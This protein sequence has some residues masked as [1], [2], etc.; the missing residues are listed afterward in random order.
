MNKNI[1]QGSFLAIAALASCGAA[2]A[3]DS[4]LVSTPWQL[5]F[6]VGGVLP[7]NLRG[8]S[9]GPLA[10]LSVGL[11]LRPGAYLEANVFG[12]R[13]SGD[14]GRDDEQTLGG[15]LDLRLERL[16]ED[17]LRY[18]F[19]FGGGYS[20]TERGSDTISAPYA[21]IGY[22]IGYELIPALEL[23]AEI[24]G[25]V[26]IDKGFIPG[27]GVTYDATSSVG[28]VYRLGREPTVVYESSRL[29][30]APPI[31]AAAPA[32]LVPNVASL[33]ARCPVAPD[34]ARVDAS[35]CLLPQRLLLPRSAFFKAQT[36]FAMQGS[37]DA[38]LYSLA[39]S[40]L[41]D[42]Q[43][44]AEISVHSEARGDPSRLMALTQSQADVLARE[45]LRQGITIERFSATGLG[46]SQPLT[47][48]ASEAA[49]EQNRR[50]E[51]NLIRR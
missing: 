24:R 15:G 33:D 39:M 3:A 21:N 16:G 49:I 11:P 6:S 37:G 43:L 32:R 38:A 8:V 40:L 25:L 30:E 17:R 14:A 31:A 51:I 46:G 50:V 47:R 23:R 48:E 4:T 13:A 18:L 22:G 10:R 26:R 29:A 5:G 44:H 42:P 20:A 7:E 34:G 41:K 12:F 9:P 1:R 19:L 2:S 36:G 35:G 45:L 28:L 27:R